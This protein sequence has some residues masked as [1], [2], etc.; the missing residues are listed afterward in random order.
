MFAVFISK[1]SIQRNVWESVPI[2]T[3]H[4]LQLFLLGAG[5]VGN[6]S[7]AS[8]PERLTYGDREKGKEDRE[9]KRLRQGDRN[10]QGAP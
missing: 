4:C 2:A 9:S 6:W 5:A 3:S 1:V 10:I 7:V 8:V